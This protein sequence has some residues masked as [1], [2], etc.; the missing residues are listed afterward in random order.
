MVVVDEAPLRPARLILGPGLKDF[1]LALAPAMRLG[2][3]AVVVLTASD[4][5]A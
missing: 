2:G 1:I 3:R 4:E 5:L